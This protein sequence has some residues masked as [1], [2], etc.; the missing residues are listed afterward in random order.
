M[1]AAVVLYYFGTGPIQGF[2]ITLAIGTVV[3]M[4]SAIVVTKFLL[5]QMVGLKLHNPSLYGVKGGADRV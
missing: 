1:I 2:A 4:F 5:R 3:S